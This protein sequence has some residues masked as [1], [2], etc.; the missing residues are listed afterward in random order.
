MK[1]LIYALAASIPAIAL[2][3]CNGTGSSS[4]STTPSSPQSIVGPIDSQ[5]FVDILSE[6]KSTKN[7]KFKQSYIANLSP[8]AQS[9][10]GPT[11]SYE[12]SSVL[13]AAKL[14]Q[15][16]LA[17]N[18]NED[19]LNQT[20]LKLENQNN[21][22]FKTYQQISESNKNNN[23]KQLNEFINNSSA[24][25]LKFKEFANGIKQSDLTKLS[26]EQLNQFKQIVSE[27]SSIAN[28]IPNISG[29]S[30]QVEQNNLTSSTPEIFKTLKDQ[31]LEKLNA[32]GNAMGYNYI[33]Y[34]KQ[35]NE[36]VIYVYSQLAQSY[37]Q[38]YAIEAV[39]NYLNFNYP[40]KQVG[41]F[42]DCDSAVYSSI[43]SPSSFNAAQAN[44]VSL[45]ADR[46]N[47]E[48]N[49]AIKYLVSDAPLDQQSSTLIN[50]Y[51][52]IVGSTTQLKTLSLDKHKTLPPGTWITAANLYQSPQILAYNE[53]NNAMYNGKVP[54]S[55]NCPAI[56]PN[57][58][59]GYYDGESMTLY[60]MKND[61]GK[62]SNNKVGT[63]SNSSADKSLNVSVPVQG[64]STFSASNCISGTPVNVVGST[65]PIDG[66]PEFQCSDYSLT[67]LTMVYNQTNTTWG[68]VFSW[69]LGNGYIRSYNASPDHFIDTLNGSFAVGDAKKDYHIYLNPGSLTES[70]TLMNG[71]GNF[72]GSGAN[73]S[74]P[75]SNGGFGSL[76]NNSANAYQTA[77]MQV[78]APNGIVIPFFI[79]AAAPYDGTNNV[80]A[81]YQTKLSLVCPAVSST[82][83]ATDGTNMVSMIGGNTQLSGCY[84]L[85][86]TTST[87]RSTIIFRFN[88][89]SS[90]QLNLDGG[91]GSE[92]NQKAYLALYPYTANNN[93]WDNMPDYGPPQT[94]SYQPNGYSGLYTQCINQ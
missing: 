29:L 28:A 24:T 33:D 90:Y 67:N 3:G 42:N 81:G 11:I 75:I 70:F 20:K 54:N 15:I 38:L 2:Y 7:S 49:T 59:N 83:P 44:L 39:A 60:F 50:E 9:V 65:N 92:G 43:K 71:H 41:I 76:H 36:Q 47:K 16:L 13:P 93:Q 62:N 79:M 88:N 10:F 21:L 48:Y 72:F 89:G 66:D 84:G 1:K 51:K 30:C 53:C 61:S 91:G 46:I 55:V 85:S 40:D 78:I 4:N 23:I 56:L 57:Q 25:Y 12:Q 22:F 32:P 31:L 18:T 8:Y 19:K 37:Q 27:A 77:G 17:T 94:C 73:N 87:E 64:Q 86:S 80:L 82:D 52:S 45:Y 34:V 58:S 68:F 6:E 35:Y 63:L 5:K 26:P 69:K 14:E 74:L